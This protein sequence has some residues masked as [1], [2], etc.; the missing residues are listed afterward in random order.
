[1]RSVMNRS[2]LNRPVRNNADDDD[3]DESI[4]AASIKQELHGCDETNSD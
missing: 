3:E 2:T 1:M 4:T